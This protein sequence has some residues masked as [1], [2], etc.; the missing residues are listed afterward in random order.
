M[1]GNDKEEEFFIEKGIHISN[2]ALLDPV[3]KEPTKIKKGFAFDP[4]IEDYRKVRISKL[5]G[6]EIPKPAPPAR[7]RKGKNST[8][9]SC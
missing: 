5:S 3:K 9:L 8:V 1:L 2:V 6:A 4:K 7:E